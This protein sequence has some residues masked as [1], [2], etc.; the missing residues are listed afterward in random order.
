MDRHDSVLVGAMKVDVLIIG[1]GIT[2]CALAYYLS[3]TTTSVAVV[4]KFDLNTRASGANAG[5]VHA[6]IMNPQIFDGE[7]GE[8]VA[9]ADPLVRILA[10][11]ARLWHD[12]ESELGETIEF[13]RTGGLVVADRPDQMKVIEKKVAFEAERG[14]H[15]DILDR[16]ALRDAAPYFSEHALGAAYCSIE[17]N[18]NSL[19]VATA[20]ARVARRNGAIFHTATELLSLERKERGYKARTSRGDYEA[21]IVVNCAGAEAGAVS[22]L[23]GITMPITGVAYQVSVSEPAE[24][25]VRHLVY[26]AGG[27]L[28]LKQT[29]RGALLIGGGWSAGFGLHDRPQI[30]LESLRDNLAICQRIV[31]Q[32]RALRIVRSWP[33]IVNHTGDTWPI[34]GEVRSMPGYFIGAFPHMGFTGGPLTA[35][36]ISEMIL[37]GR[38]EFDMSTFSP[39]RFHNY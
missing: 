13:T 31:P 26:Y 25:L 36:S 10:S 12:L 7:H 32:S 22:Q 24:P 19:V 35:K 28:T 3:K 21:Q 38:S 37:H 9:K 17:G 8:D 2:G 30:L 15:V 20:F 18:A 27:N 34:I 4:E 6:Q 5:S 16:A 11:A 14:L 1:G 23:L 29:A 33:G 39:N